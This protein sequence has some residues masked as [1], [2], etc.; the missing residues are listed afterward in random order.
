MTASSQPVRQN[1]DVVPA[2]FRDQIPSGGDACRWK[3]RGLAERGKQDAEK[4]PAE[5]R[6]VQVIQ[7]SQ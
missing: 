7:G 5:I 1:R 2:D 6:T 4:L 3:A